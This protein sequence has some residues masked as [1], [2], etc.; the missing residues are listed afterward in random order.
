MR[1]LYKLAEDAKEELEREIAIGQLKSDV[2]WRFV[3]TLVRL[4]LYKR[5]RILGG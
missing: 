3:D 5:I 1:K 4:G 2:R